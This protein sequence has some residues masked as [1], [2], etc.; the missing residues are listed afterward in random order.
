MAGLFKL[1]GMI[2]NEVKFLKLALSVWPEGNEVEASAATW[3][4]IIKGYSDLRLYE[5]AYTAI[6]SSPHHEEYVRRIENF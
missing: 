1:A 6:I 5:D 2:S 3:S 4:A